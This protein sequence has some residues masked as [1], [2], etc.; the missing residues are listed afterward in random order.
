[1]T[2]TSQNSAICLRSYKATPSIKILPQTLPSASD[3]SHLCAW[4]VAFSSLPWLRQGGRPIVLTV[5]SRCHELAFFTFFS[6]LFYCIDT[7]CYSPKHY[8]KHNFTLLVIHFVFLLCFRPSRKSKS[9]CIQSHNVAN[10]TLK[11]TTDDPFWRRRKRQG[12][13]IVR[14]NDRTRDP[15]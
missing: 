13:L 8:F 9:A 5:K 4:K 11:T 3:A 15:L 1:M 12:Y 6:L 7:C 2:P 14:K 10:T